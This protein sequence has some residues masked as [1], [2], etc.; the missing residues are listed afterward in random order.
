CAP[1]EHVDDARGRDAAVAVV[2]TPDGEI[3]ESVVVPVTRGERTAESVAVRRRALDGGP[4]VLGEEQVVSV[5]E[6]AGRPEDD[7]HDAVLRVRAVVFGGRTDG[8]IAVTVS[9]VVARRQLAAEVVD[10]LR[11]SDDAGRVLGPE[12]GAI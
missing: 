7:V 8:E 2:P 5:R 9:V 10:D 6:A 11:R 12:L 3:V 1:V 4:G